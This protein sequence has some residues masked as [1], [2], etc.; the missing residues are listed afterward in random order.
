MGAG[1]V[2]LLLA[3]DLGLLV[4]EVLTWVMQRRIVLAERV[5]QLRKELAETEAEVARLEAAEV[6]IGQSVEAERAARRTM[7]SWTRSWSASPRRVV[8]PAGRIGNRGRT[9]A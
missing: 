5:Q 6:V 2:G 9:T 4:A 8:V 1:P 7:P 3:G